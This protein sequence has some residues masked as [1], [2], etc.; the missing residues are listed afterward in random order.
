MPEKY[1]FKQDAKLDALL[2]YAAMMGVFELGAIRAGLNAN[3]AFAR[4][5]WLKKQP[6]SY[7]MAVAEEV[8]RLEDEAAKERGA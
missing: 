4:A 3:E 8:V 6:E 5:D 2:V 1:Q 7:V